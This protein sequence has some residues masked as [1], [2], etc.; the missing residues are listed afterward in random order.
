MREIY[1]EIVYLRGVYEQKRC[2]KKQQ[3]C[4]SKVKYFLRF[5]MIMTR[6]GSLMPSVS[7]GSA[8]HVMKVVLALV[9]VCAELV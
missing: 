6:K 5:L 7:L 2:L 1:R 4:T 9:R 3:T 8:G